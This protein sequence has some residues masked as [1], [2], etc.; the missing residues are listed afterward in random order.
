MDRQTRPLSVTL[1]ARSWL[2]KPSVIPSCRVLL[3]AEVQSILLDLVN[4][5]EDVILDSS[6]KQI[7]RFG[8]RGWED[9]PKGQ[10]WTRSGQLVLFQFGNYPDRLDLNLWVDL[11]PEEARQRLIDLAKV[12]QPPCRV[13]KG[14][15]KV[16]KLIYSRCF[17]RPED[18]LDA[19]R[20]DIE[21]RIRAQ[22]EEFADQDL[23]RLVAPIKEAIPAIASSLVDGDAVSRTIPAETNDAVMIEHN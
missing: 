7:V 5:R 4:S 3:L 21:A 12:H 23:P 11:G 9:L 17:L 2:G 18:F 19:A 20:K 15:S 1:D 16:F 14:N 8:H 22:W 10:G 6:S 13:P